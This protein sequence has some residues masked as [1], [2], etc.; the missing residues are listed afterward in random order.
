MRGAGLWPAMPAF[1]RACL[2]EQGR[3]AGSKAVVSDQRSAPHLTPPRRVELARPLPLSRIEA[4]A[5]T[6]LHPPPPCLPRRIV[7]S[8]AASPAGLESAAGWRDAW[9]LLRRTGRSL[10][11]APGR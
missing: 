2:T 10:R 1:E 7:R 9:A 4:C 6:D 8:G 5:W 3:H 11:P